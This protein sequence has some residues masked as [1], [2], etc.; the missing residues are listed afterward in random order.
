MKVK[1]AGFLELEKK[2]AR[3]NITLY[4]L[5]VDIIGINSFIWDLMLECYTG[6]FKAGTPKYNSIRVGC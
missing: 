6:F 4:G 3:L 5:V 2:P 1:N